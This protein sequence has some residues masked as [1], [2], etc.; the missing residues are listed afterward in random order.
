M[1]LGYRLHSEVMFIVYLCENKCVYV[2]CYEVEKC[3]NCVLYAILY[4]F[5]IF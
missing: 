2:S 3:E 5:S 1:R 4:A